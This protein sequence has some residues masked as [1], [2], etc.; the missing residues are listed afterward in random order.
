[1]LSPKLSRRDSTALFLP[2]Y[3]KLARLPAHSLLSW[4][5]YL[6]HSRCLVLAPGRAD[7]HSLA[8]LPSTRAI[9]D[10]DVFYVARPAR[11]ILTF[12]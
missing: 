12:S 6:D 10:R 9:P 1:M 4:S 7:L 5:L 8:A 11:S 2:F 3:L